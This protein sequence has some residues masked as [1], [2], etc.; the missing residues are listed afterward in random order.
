MAEKSK[1]GF[2]ATEVLARAGVKRLYTVPGESFLEVLDAAERHPDLALISTRHESGASFM[3]EADAKLTGMP[4]VAM[5]TRG[6]GAS[7]LAI[8]VHTAMQD[9]S[10]MLVLLGQVETDF[11]GKEAFQEV[12]LPAFYAPITKWSATVNR[13]DRLA[14]FVARGLRIA[15]SGRPGPVMLALPADVL[16]EDVAANPEATVQTS[17]VAGPE[18]EQVQAV[19]R[20]LGAARR[21]VVIAG[22]GARGAREALVSF[23]ETFGAGV[24]ASFRRQDAFPNDHP[25]YL[26]HLALGT[27]PETL[28]ALDEADLV[29]V[30]GCRL[31]EVT[32]QSYSLP[33]GNQT[34]IQIDVDPDEVGATVPVE[35]GMVSDARSAL[36][37]FEAQ[38]SPEPSR[39]D[40]TEAHAAYLA[41]STIPGART[42]DGIDPSQVVKAMLET[43]PADSL[44]AND[45]GNFSVFVHRYWRY[46]HPDTQLAPAN[47]AMGYGVP[48]AVAAKLAAPDR[49]VVS[50]CGDGGFLM[51]GQELETAVRYGAPITV[52]VFRNGLQGTIAMHQQRD[53]GRVAGVDIGAV[54]LAGF[55]R[56]LGAEGHTVSEPDE[57]VPALRAAWSS[58]AVSLVDVIT[59]ADIISPTA[60]LSELAV[61]T[62]PSS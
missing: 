41:S 19:V 37:A 34:V 3:A 57:L 51:T 23:A 38:A 58:D 25:N 62:S 16:G 43:L 44:L 59:D 9:S 11:L 55:A 52:I 31:G 33:H 42:S 29:L 61:D 53:L 18:P 35:I 24:Y 8:G 32:T 5:A 46:N 2:V 26:G 1:A 14:E 28:R 45:A 49:T 50:C 56:S 39:R 20:R 27:P 15:T 40:W 12:D 47:G 21:P 10:P 48:A 30:V 36:A 4:A 22:G 6:V 17:P 13:A 7:N 60:R 54:D